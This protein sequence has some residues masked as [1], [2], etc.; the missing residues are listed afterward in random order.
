M[1]ELDQ[2]NADEMKMFRESI[3]A[4]TT[5]IENGFSML[6]Q[7]MHPL[8]M[9]S[10]LMQMQP[11]PQQ[12]QPHPIHTSQ[13]LSTPPYNNCTTPNVPRNGHKNQSFRSMM[14][15]IIQEK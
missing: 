10:H 7:S 15:D 8:P 11:Q 5:L 13:N 12:M 3:H 4:L 6:Q 9:Q 1:E 2:R 14:E